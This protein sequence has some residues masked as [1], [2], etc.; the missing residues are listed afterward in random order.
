MGEVN[1]VH[2]VVDRLSFVH[3]AHLNAVL[4]VIHKLL[5]FLNQSTRVDVADLTNCLINGRRRFGGVHQHQAVCE[6]R[7]IEWDTVV[8]L[9]LRA[10]NMVIA[11]ILQ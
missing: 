1:E 7:L 6:L 11:Q 3:V 2:D 5:V 4:E 9:Y 10:V 8:S